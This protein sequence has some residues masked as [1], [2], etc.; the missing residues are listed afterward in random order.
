MNK[1]FNIEILLSNFLK[2]MIYLFFENNK[3]NYK[4][5]L[6]RVKLLILQLI[7]L[8]LLINSSWGFS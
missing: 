1:F 4:E 6:L 7:D 2:S 3:I 5:I 8:F